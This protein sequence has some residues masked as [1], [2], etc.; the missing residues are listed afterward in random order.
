MVTYNAYFGNQSN[1][2]TMDL[3]DSY[4]FVKLQLE[5]DSIKAT[6]AYL[7]N[8]K[9]L[10]SYKDVPTI[11]WQKQLFR[12]A[13][14][15][16][17]NIAIRGGN[18]DTKY[19]L[20]GSFLNQDGTILASNFKRYQG[21]ASIDQRI[22]SKLKVGLNVNYSHLVTTGTPTG[23]N[24]SLTSGT[25]QTQNNLLIN[26]WQYRPINQSGNLDELLNNAQDADVISSTNYQWNPVLSAQNQIRNRT[27]KLLFPFG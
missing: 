1:T 27:T 23:G 12:S 26:M 15:Q 6:A 7:A 21:R 14:M 18:N 11:D 4:N 10:D 5:V 22:N 17:H 25:F 3:M 2:K 8:G 9:T 13:P 19:S 24:T 20:S 16:N